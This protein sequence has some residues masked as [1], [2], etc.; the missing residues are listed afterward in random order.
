MFLNPNSVLSRHLRIGLIDLQ[1][2]RDL[3]PFSTFLSHTQKENTNLE[4]KK[5]KNR[6][7]NDVNIRSNK[8]TNV[9]I[10]PICILCIRLYAVKKLRKMALNLTECDG[11]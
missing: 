3:N 6:N 10:L 2:M 9:K 7:T 11:K 8:S 4:V 1:R 5:T